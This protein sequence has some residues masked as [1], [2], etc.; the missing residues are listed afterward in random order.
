MDKIKEINVNI[1]DEK[2][3][4]RLYLVNNVITNKYKLVDI[5]N[6]KESFKN[7]LSRFKEPNKLFVIE[8]KNDIKGILTFTKQKA[9]D[10]TD[11]YVLEASL[12]DKKIDKA[13][14][15]EIEKLVEDLGKEYRPIALNLYNKELDEVAKKFNGKIRL[16]AQSYS[17][18][19]EDINIDKL[20][21]TM[22]QL[23]EKNKDLT[24]N[25]FIDVP[26]EYVDSY[27]KLF[28]DGT[29]DMPD[30][31]EEGFVWNAV[32]HEFVKGMKEGCKKNNGTHYCCLVVNLTNEVVAMSNIMVNNND[33]RYP[34]QFMIAVSREYRGRGLG[35]WMYSCAYKKLC[36]NVDFEKVHLYHH[37]RN[38]H[39]ISVSEYIGYKK[40][41]LK[42]TYILAS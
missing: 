12:V 30:A 11:Q 36:E 25:C 15:K 31:K 28:N 22:K 27:C 6:T 20:N 29:K 3:L 9:W 41:H 1:L 19:K 34:Y 4:D 17:L 5:Y 38:K 39:A 42:V 23:S 32:T 7:Y 10:G 33:P 37:P 26:E 18:K 40:Q 14:S 35:R 21:S 2:Q 8:S 24:I 16:N 13:L